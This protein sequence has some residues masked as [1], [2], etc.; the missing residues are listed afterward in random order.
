[1]ANERMPQSL[2]MGAYTPYNAVIGD[3]VF[4]QG[5]GRLRK[6]LIVET[7]GS[8]FVVAYVTPSNHH[9]LKYKTLP[10]SRLYIKEKA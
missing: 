5:H 2:N 3:Q 6:G 8:R 9:D 10:L 4:I 1:M 7:T